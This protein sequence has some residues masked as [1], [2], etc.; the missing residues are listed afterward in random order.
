MTPKTRTRERIEALK[1]G[2]SIYLPGVKA[3]TPAYMKVLGY[4][5]R[6]KR[7]FA[8]RAFEMRTRKKSLQ[9]KR[10]KP[11]EQLCP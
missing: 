9:V 4:I 2:Q 5:Q 3:K 10:C 11:K 7:D 6:V 8:G 1:V